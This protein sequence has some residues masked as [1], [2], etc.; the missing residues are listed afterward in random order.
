MYKLTKDYNMK[1]IIKDL[2]WLIAII[3]IIVIIATSCKK[4]EKQKV[5]TC[6]VESNTYLKSGGFSTVGYNKTKSTKEIITNKRNNCSM[7]DYKETQY[8]D[9]VSFVKEIVTTSSCK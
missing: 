1:K 6:Q 9:T 4:Q 2:L 5:C 8:I 7:F 3:T